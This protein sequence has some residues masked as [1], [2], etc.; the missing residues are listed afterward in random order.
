MNSKKETQIKKTYEKPRYSIIKENFI[1]A[2][3]TTISSSSNHVNNKQ[4]IA[5]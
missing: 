3:T 4:K 1:N 5:Q 2:R